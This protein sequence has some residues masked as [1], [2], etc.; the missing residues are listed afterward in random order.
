MTAIEQASESDIPEL[1]KLL[2]ILFKQEIEFK[3]DTEAQ[4]KA[5]TSIIKNLET[6]TILVTRESG[7]ILGMVSLLFTV[8]TAL[9]NK[10][11]L[12]EDLVVLPEARGKGIG[13]NLL[14]GAIAF[15][16]SKGCLRI[17]LLTDCDNRLARQLYAKH[18]FSNSSMIPMRLSL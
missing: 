15:A 9:G 17:T 3:P 16:K 6:G 10:V 18:G 8:S 2:S 7:K 13:S 14:S 4:R 5:L 1:C 12:L 11:A